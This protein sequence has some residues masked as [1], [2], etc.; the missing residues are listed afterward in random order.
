[1]WHKSLR[2]NPLT[3]A[4]ND[5]IG[6]VCVH[7]ESTCIYVFGVLMPSSNLPLSTFRDTL[8]TLCDTHDRY[9]EDGP[10]ILMGDFN[11]QISTCHGEN[12]HP[13]ANDRGECIEQFMCDREL[14]SINSQSSTGPSYTYLSGDGTHSS[15]I[16]H[17]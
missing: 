11:A 16:D 6:G 4:G 1:M 14:I 15:M 5:R 12:N 10:V 9:I 13:C 17:C 3:H 7:V 8:E 2:V